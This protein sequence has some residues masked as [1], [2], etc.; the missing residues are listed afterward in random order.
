MDG[1][2]KETWKE[3]KDPQDDQINDRTSEKKSNQKK[4]EDTQIPRGWMESRLESTSMRNTPHQ[5]ED[6]IT[7]QYL[8]R[9]SD[10]T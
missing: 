5:E 4:K 6:E 10:K 1:H 3:K 9:G 8:E 2:K 7:I